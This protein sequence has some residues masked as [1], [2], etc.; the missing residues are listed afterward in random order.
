VVSDEITNGELHRNIL[1]L[2]LQVAN[3]YT[4]AKLTNGRMRR[5]EVA[6]AVLQVGYVLG[7][8]VLSAGLMWLV[9]N[10]NRG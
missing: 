1:E 9:N 3:V 10:W 8:A 7:A 6:I 5:N 4:E 2:K